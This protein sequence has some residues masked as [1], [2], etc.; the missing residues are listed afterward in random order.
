MVNSSHLGLVPSRNMS[1]HKG[2]FQGADSTS[3]D[4][5]VNLRA[6]V[7]SYLQTFPNGPS[8][9]FPNSGSAMSQHLSFSG[10][11]PA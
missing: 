2:I 3:D 8:V 4:D 7:R 11:T 6:A 5:M 1:V 9:P 10:F